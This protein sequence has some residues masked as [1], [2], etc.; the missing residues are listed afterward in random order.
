MICKYCNKKYENN[1]I[2]QHISSTHRNVYEEK[3]K[4]VDLNIFQFDS[5][6]DINE[7]KC[8]LVEFEKLKQIILDNFIIENKITPIFR[9]KYFID[10]IG[11]SVF[12]SIFYYTRHLIKDSTFKHRIFC[13]LNNINEYPKCK[14]GNIITKTFENSLKNFSYNLYC[15]QSCAN[16]YTNFKKPKEYYKAIT[17]KVVKTRKKN[18]SYKLSP[19]HREVFWSEESN[20]KRKETNLK[21]YGVANPGVLGAYSSKAAFNYITKFL[22]ENNI[23]LKH[24]YYK[25]GGV[26]NKE[27][28]QYISIDNGENKYVS[29]DLVVFEDVNSAKNKDL[30]KIILV[31][32][33]NGPWHYKKDEV[34]FSKS[35]P[36]TPYKN[37]KTKL[38]SYNG[39]VF[40]LTHIRK[41]CDNILIYWEKSDTLEKFDYL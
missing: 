6:K 37:S 5:K 34:I 23:P 35:E 32:E 28:F 12:K 41:F 2:L 10:K 20:I 38:E 18:N 19:K 29:Y 24:A 3:L 8:I 4:I 13:I 21:K 30:S 33:Y 25:N 17:K 26:N 7:L 31:L 36:A 16:R 22:E 1:Q 40:K 9:R 27:F 14:C 15:S 39:D 11:E